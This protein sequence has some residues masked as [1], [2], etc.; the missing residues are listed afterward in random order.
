[1]IGPDAAAAAERFALAAA[2]RARRASAGLESRRVAELIGTNR[3]TYYRWETGREPIPEPRRKQLDR[4]FAEYERAAER[5][6]RWN[7]RAA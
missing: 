2:L 5:F 4:L 3:T 7:G 6:D 1:M